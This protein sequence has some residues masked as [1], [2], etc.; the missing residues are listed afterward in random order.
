M[1]GRESKESVRV[2][3]AFT[4][5]SRHVIVRQNDHAITRPR[6]RPYRRL[7]AARPPR[8]HRTCCTQRVRTRNRYHHTRA[9]PRSCVYLS[10]RYDGTA[11][12]FEKQRFSTFFFFTSAYLTYDLPVLRL[13]VLPLI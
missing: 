11:K 3:R 4:V 8:Q 13:M 9:P 2:R 7:N 6:L 10:A 1:R 12:L 5:L